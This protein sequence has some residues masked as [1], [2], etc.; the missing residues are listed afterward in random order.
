MLALAFEV[1]SGASGQGLVLALVVTA[2]LFL[3]LRR[4][5]ARLDRWRP[6]G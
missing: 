5:T 3:L 1:H 6:R 2:G 4:G